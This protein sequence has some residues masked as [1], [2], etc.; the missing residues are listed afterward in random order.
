LN[1]VVASSN[2]T[3]CFRRF[4]TAFVRS[5][6]YSIVRTPSLSWLRC[7]SHDAD[8][9]VA[10][11][12]L[13]K[14]C[15]RSTWMTSGTSVTDTDGHGL[16]KVFPHCLS[17]HSALSPLLGALL[18]LISD[19]A[20]NMAKINFG[21]V[22]ESVVTREEFPLE[23]AR[24]VLKNEVICVIATAVQA[25]AQALNMRDNGFKVII[26]QRPEREE[27]TGTRPSP[28]AGSPARLLSPSSRPPRR[29]PSSST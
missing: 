29:P 21:G 18:R 25:P 26:G 7:P 5:H 1:T 16:T 17:P 27:N 24:E 20:D 15:R 4:E 23:K 19:G 28:M 13:K 2:D 12:A 11:N 6:S 10:S 14:C 8:C 3:P 9:P 22:M